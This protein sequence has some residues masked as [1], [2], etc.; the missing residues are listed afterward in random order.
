MDN[1]PEW[2]EIDRMPWRTILGDLGCYVT[3]R[4]DQL[5][6]SHTWARRTGGPG[7]TFWR[8]L[9]GMAPL[10]GFMLGLWLVLDFIQ[11]HVVIIVL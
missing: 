5:D 9:A 10:V 11:R 4:S 3:S 6:A 1:R 7:G 2:K 8:N